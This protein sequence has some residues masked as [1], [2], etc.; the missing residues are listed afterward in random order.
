VGV[1]F[2]IQGASERRLC[3]GPSQTVSTFNLSTSLLGTS[4]LFYRKNILGVQSVSIIYM[5][6]SSN[7]KDL[8]WSF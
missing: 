1:P 5:L 3:T 6:T 2:E 4:S 7:I 8:T